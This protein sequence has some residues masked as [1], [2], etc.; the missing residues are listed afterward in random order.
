MFAGTEN[1]IKEIMSTSIH[2]RAR[3]H[4]HTHTTD[5]TRKVGKLNMSICRQLIPAKM[6]NL[7]S[8]YRAVANFSDC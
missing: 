5:A 7:I 4:T 1:E 2:A 6:S 3:T 8:K